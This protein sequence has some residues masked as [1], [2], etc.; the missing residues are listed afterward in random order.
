[1]KCVCVCAQTAA[2][3][4]FLFYF[5]SIFHNAEETPSQQQLRPKANSQQP[6]T[7]NEQNAAAIGTSSQSPI[8]SAKP[9]QT[10]NSLN[11]SQ[12]HQMVSDETYHILNHDFV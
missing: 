1:M 12:Q 4:N 2:P 5:I 11:N 3:V 8:G 6:V 10:Q 9:Q 7:E